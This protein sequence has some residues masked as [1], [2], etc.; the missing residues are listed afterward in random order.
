MGEDEDDV[1]PLLG[2]APGQALARGAQ[3]PGDLGGELPTEHEYL[4][5]RASWMNVHARMISPTLQAW[6]MHPAGRWGALPS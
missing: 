1:V 3:A 6:V 5:D 4:H 2:E